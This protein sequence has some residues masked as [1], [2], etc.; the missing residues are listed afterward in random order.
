MIDSLG[1]RGDGVARDHG[2]EVFIPYTLP[3]ERILARVSE[4]RGAVEE[5]LS[6]SP[7]RVSAPCLHFGDC[8]G[9]ALQHAARGFYLD[10]KRAL[11]VETLARAGLA[12]APVRET[13]AVDAPTRRR[14]TF[15]V[16]RTGEGAVVGFNARASHRIVEIAAC[17][18]LHPALFNALPGLKRLA[19]ALPAEWR[20]FDMAVTLC[21]NGLDVDLAP[22]ARVG[23]L[24]GANLQRLGEVMQEAAV[25][26]LSVDRA[27]LLTL[28]PP[29]VRFGGVPVSPPAGGFLQA[30]AAGEAAL[31]G[32][33]GRSADGARRALDLFCGAG[34]FSFPLSKS[35]T[36][37]AID[38]DRA[39][40]EALAAGARHSPFRP[41]TS[42]TRNLFERPLMADELRDYDMIVFDPPRAGAREQAAEIAR[43]R[44][45]RVIGV[46]CN[47]ATF[48]RDAALLAAGGYS[49]VEVTPVDQF[50]YSPHVELVGVFAKR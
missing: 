30:S 35:A 17:E 37:H 5:V 6:A 46:S 10:W 43:A 1:A 49:L 42:E 11:V 45:P 41:I 15:A 38:S 50:V 12:D 19:A 33:V 47:P 40:V 29:V 7:H 44:V 39:A 2:A 32:L 34:A 22:S 16:K 14:A 26:R 4:R 21:D 13:V 24:Q 25:A 23:E 48:A 28:S 18:I 9:C 31:V 27:P 20:A 8:G 36:V 3:G